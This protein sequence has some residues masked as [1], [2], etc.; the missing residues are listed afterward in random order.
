MRKLKITELN[1]LTVDEFK[2]ADKLPLA[3]VLDEVRSLHNI[4]SVFRT[5]DAFLVDCIYLCGITATPPHPEMHKT[6]LGAENS[7]E[8]RYKKNTL[9]AVQELHDQGFIVLA[10]EQVEGSTLLDKL[11]LDADKKYAI[12]RYREDRWLKSF[13]LSRHDLARAVEDRRSHPFGRFIYPE[14]EETTKRRLLSTEAGYLVCALS[15]LMWTPFSPS[16]SKCAKAE[17]CRRR[18]QARYPE[19]YRIRCEA[20]RKKEAKP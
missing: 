9:D 15:T 2:K 1:R 6:A 19:L 13:G 11:E 16:C 18:T 20:W 17:P 12:G 7:V 3:V 8:W 10:I 14:Y 5:S 4:G